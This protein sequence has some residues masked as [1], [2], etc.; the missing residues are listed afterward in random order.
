MR[1]AFHYTFLCENGYRGAGLF[2]ADTRLTERE[3]RKLAFSDAYDCGFRRVQ[4]V[5]VD[6]IGG[7]DNAN[8]TIRAKRPA[9][10]VAAILP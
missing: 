8:A 7:Y 4:S 10:G 9:P 6:T 5:T 3:L 2:V 1:T